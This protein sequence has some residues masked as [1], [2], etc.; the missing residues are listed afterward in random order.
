M[1]LKLEVRCCC[2]PVKLM[3]WLHVDHALLQ[4]KT[5]T[6]APVR[7]MQNIPRTAIPAQVTLAF[8]E[9]AMITP[10]DTPH[11]ERSVLSE[12]V[13]YRRYV[14]VKG[15]GIPLETLKAIPEFEANPEYC[16]EQ[17]EGA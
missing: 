3:G 5:A 7:S 4:S 13:T 1:K 2:K 8:A 10:R 14:A 16:D 12:G 9:I 11:G 15:E 17:S 6:F